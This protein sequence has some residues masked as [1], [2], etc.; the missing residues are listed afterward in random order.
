MMPARRRRR[1]PPASE[2]RPDAMTGNV[3]GRGRFTSLAG[4]RPF[5]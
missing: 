1:N 3:W 2:N 5:R 4:L